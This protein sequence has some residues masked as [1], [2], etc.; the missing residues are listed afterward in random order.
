MSDTKQKALDFLE[1]NADIKE[2]FATSDSFLF[3][4]KSDATEHAKT[5]NEDSPKVET[6]TRDQKKS[7][8]DETPKLSPTEQKALKDSAIAEYKKL[9]GADP[10][11]KLSGPKIQVL[12]DAKR[13]ELENNKNPE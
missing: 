13:T 1:S 12:N 8:T 6:F 9:F 7:K 2:V 3:I 5:L 11:A 10:D 4:K